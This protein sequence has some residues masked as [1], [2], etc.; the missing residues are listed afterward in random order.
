MSESERERDERLPM[1]VIDIGHL[2][3]MP[4]LPAGSSRTEIRNA[5]EETVE[6]RNAESLQRRAVEEGEETNVENGND[7]QRAGESLE[8]NDAPNNARKA[9]AGESTAVAEES[10][11][12]PAEGSSGEED[13]AKR[14]ARES[15]ATVPGTR[16]GAV[17]FLSPPAAVKATAAGT[18]VAMTPT[19]TPPSREH[20]TTG[21]ASA[22]TTDARTATHATTNQSVTHNQNALAHTSTATSDLR[23]IPLVPVPAMCSR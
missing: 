4:R 1:P 21:Q 20:T 22:S 15:D 6:R 23:C 8:I 5:V 16:S 11:K 17:S 19:V 18:R 12:R 10:R 13:N 7:G 2:L 14:L 9:A 3:G